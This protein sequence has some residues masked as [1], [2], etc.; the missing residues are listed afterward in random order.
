MPI[1]KFFIWLNDLS[2]FGCLERVEVGESGHFQLFL[3]GELITDK[4]I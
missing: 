2:V 3:G 1:Y 4:L